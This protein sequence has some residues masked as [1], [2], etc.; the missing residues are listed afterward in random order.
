ML[1]IINI[2][3]SGE[4]CIYSRLVFIQIQAKTINVTTP[5]VMFDQPLWLK[6]PEIVISKKL[7]IVVRLGG[8]H[9]LSFMG[10]IGNIIMEGEIVGL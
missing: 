8:L 3:P 10:S 6:A 1:S 2:N 5:S 7:K 9:T 4:N